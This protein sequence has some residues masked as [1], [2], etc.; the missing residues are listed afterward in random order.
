MEAALEFV[1]KIREGSAALASPTLGLVFERGE[2]PSAG[3]LVHVS[4]DVEGEV[5]DSLQVAGADVEQ[6]AQPRRRALEVPD[7]A[8]GAG[9][10]NV[11]HALPANLGASDLHAAFVADDSLVPKPLVLAAVAL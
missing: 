11:A 7:V 4:N 5:E 2:C 8:N 1:L 9:Q 3:I 6:D 10:L